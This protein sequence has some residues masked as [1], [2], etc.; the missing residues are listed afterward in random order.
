LLRSI[1]LFCMYRNVLVHTS[2]LATE[3]MGPGYNCAYNLE[4]GFSE[5]GR[6]I[7]SPYYLCDCSHLRNWLWLSVA[8]YLTEYLCDW[9]TSS[10]FWVFQWPVGFQAVT[11][12]TDCGVCSWPWKWFAAT[13]ADHPM[14][15][16][17]N[18]PQHSLE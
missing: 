11:T 14:F 6:C 8:G 5:W 16:T 13:K 17:S 1:I 10:V 12:V 2:I 18:L 7:S 4:E 9:L 15:M 3:T